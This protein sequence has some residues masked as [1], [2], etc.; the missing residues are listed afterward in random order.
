MGGSTIGVTVL[1]TLLVPQYNYL[2]S[3]PVLL[4][5]GVPTLNDARAEI[6]FND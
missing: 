2:S 1:I 3:I 5:M 4:Y 6:L